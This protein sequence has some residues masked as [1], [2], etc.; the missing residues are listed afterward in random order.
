MPWAL[1][2]A[3]VVCSWRRASP[4]ALGNPAVAAAVGP[5][6][7]AL[8]AAAFLAGRRLG[9]AFGALPWDHAL[10]LSLALSLGATVAL[11]GA[12]L[13]LLAPGSTTLDPQL[14]IAPVSRTGIFLSATALPF[15]LAT[16]GFIAVAAS[17]LIPFTAATPGGARA[18]LVVLVG[19]LAAVLL[20]AVTAV[21]AVALAR[22]SGVGV[23]ALSTV[24]VLW[25][26]AAVTAEGEQLAGP[27]AHVAGVLVEPRP[28]LLRPLCVLG[29]AALAAGAA[30]A[31]AAVTL[32]AERPRRASV[33]AALRIP[34]RPPLACFVA[35]LKRH[36]R[37][38]ELRRHAG[39][40]VASTSGGGFLATAV[41]ASPP[42]FTLL[43]GAGLAVL[44]A[45]LF[46]L[47]AAGLDQGA[48]W[49]W[50]SVPQRGFTLAVATLLSAVTVG[51]AVVCASLAPLAVAFPASVR[52]YAALVAP[53]FI[54][55]GA[56]L[57]AGAVVPWHPDRVLDQL[58]SLAFVGVAT[59]TVSVGIAAAAPAAVRAGVPDAFF[60]ILTAACFFFAALGAGA[61]LARRATT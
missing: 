60:W 20:G 38:P 4:I 41:L 17:F 2:R 27:F 21:G 13:A 52:S 50:A 58:A 42:A 1:F 56:A 12:A 6:I 59:A 43:F 10:A 7:L 24:G 25:G 47:A 18:T 35:G 22:G 57:L 30:W 29:L 46:P 3:T 39:V 33:R 32:P 28:Q 15:F 45:A 9:A 51:A 26:A 23:G 11:A 53:A 49:L 44:G 61:A 31:W 48:S 5:A 19:A 37:R 55:F 34:S 40:V 14:R 8:P 36:S 16:A 54:A